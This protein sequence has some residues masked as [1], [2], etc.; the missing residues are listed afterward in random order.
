[1]KIFTFTATDPEAPVGAIARIYLGKKEGWHP[2]IFSA[3]NADAARTNAE[4]WWET[5]SAKVDRRRSPRRAKEQPQAAD[6]GDV[7]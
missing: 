2:V 7:I 5:E 6:P 1:M 3:A 4:A